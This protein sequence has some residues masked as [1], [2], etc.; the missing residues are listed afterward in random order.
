MLL[1]LII[2]AI[3]RSVFGYHPWSTSSGSFLQLGHRHRTFGAYGTPTVTKYITS[4]S[5]Q[6]QPHNAYFEH[7]FAYFRLLRRLVH[8]LTT[9]RRKPLTTSCIKHDV[10]RSLRRRVVSVCTRRRKRRKY[11]K[12]CSK[13]A[14]CG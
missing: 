4:T 7:N 3:Q 5:R 6:Q 12:L 10:V 13:Y 1:S 8:A 14:L 9:Q 11:A 2:K